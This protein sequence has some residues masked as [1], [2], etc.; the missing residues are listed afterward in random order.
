MNFVSNRQSG[1]AFF[2]ILIAI[3]LFATLTYAV[4]RSS[5]VSEG[6]LSANQA[7]LAAQE[8]IS[9]GNTL[10]DTVQKLRIRGCAENQLDIANTVWQFGNG[11]L[12]HPAG[13]N[14]NAPASGCSVF[15][16][17]DGKMQP[18]IMPLS[19]TIGGTVGA[20]NT[21][22]GHSRLNL[23]RVTNVGDAAK[24]DMVLLIARLNLQ[25]CLKINEILGVT[26]P[27]NAPPDY[28]V[29]TTVLYKGTFAD[30]TTMTDTSTVLSGKTAFCAIR[31]G[32]YEFNQVLM[33][34]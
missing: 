20:S 31:N 2:I 16:I 11:T 6:S 25:V 14:P 17:N 1:S 9:Y 23:L 3:V 34:R 5:R 12:I 22:L 19:Y 18:M 29:S 32:L 8:I 26:N 10:A 28:T 15:S 13:D 4:M 7:K 21:Q 30:T 33:V 24:E 27:S